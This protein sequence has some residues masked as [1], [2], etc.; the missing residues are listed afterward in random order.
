MGRPGGRSLLSTWAR[1]C[2]MIVVGAAEFCTITSTVAKITA[3]TFCR[4]QYREQKNR[5]T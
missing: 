5:E 1:E 2:G 3:S 4:V